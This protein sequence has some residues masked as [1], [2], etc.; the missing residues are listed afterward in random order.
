M[1]TNISGFPEFLPNEQIA[2]NKVLQIIRETFELYGFSP[3]D[4]VAVEKVSTLLS[5]G[6]DHEI[7]GI[8]RLSGGG[9]AA[10]KD[11][12]L[13]FD[14]TV[15]L[16][17]Y[18]SQNFGHLVFPYKRY[19][20]APV[21]RGERAQAGRYRQFYQ[22]D[23]DIIGDG[24]LSLSY[25]TEVLSVIYHVLRKIGL[26]RYVIKVN[27]R[28]ILGG[29]LKVFGFAED[30]MPDAMRIIDKIG[31][32]DVTDIVHELQSYLPEN[33]DVS[34]IHVFLNMTAGLD[35]WMTYLKALPQNPELSDGIEELSTVLTQLPIHGVDMEKIQIDPT[36]A[37]GLAYYTG[38]VCETKL[39][40]FP[41]L[42]SVCGGGR[43][44]NLASGFS[45]KQLPG[46]GISIGVSRL[47]PKLIEM[48]YLDTRG[49][50]PAKV[51]VTTQNPKHM[52][53]YIQI[54]KLL[55]EAQ[56]P[57]EIYLQE[58]NLGTQIKYADKKGIP[59]VIIADSTELSSQQVMVKNLASGDQQHIKISDINEFFRKLR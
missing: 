38:T 10:K 59:Y 18:V 55:R 57:S 7:Y 27:N 46:V 52:H 14:L 22:C 2:F 54:I 4:T 19:Q 51:L 48:G 21:W 44:A 29:V 40:D 53:E 9:E 41:E 16:A 26:D 28:K 3:L 13:R 39:L 5:K 17:R 49:E 47:V 36:L 32:I 58:K 45:K 30:A 31:K 50:T 43:Y 37:R 1:L 33:H 56:I 15:P 42:G 8:Y 34:N 11:L 24:D 12:A 25:D 35:E 20:I 6:N 23:V